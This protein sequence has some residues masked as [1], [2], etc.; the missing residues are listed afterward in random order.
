MPCQR[1]TVARMLGESRRCQRCL[2]NCLLVKCVHPSSQLHD[3]SAWQA[4]ELLRV[5]PAPCV[6][7]ARLPYPAE[8][9]AAEG[10]SAS[11]MFTQVPLAD[12]AA[13]GSLICYVAPLLHCVRIDHSRTFLQVLPAAPSC[14]LPCGFL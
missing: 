12:P 4:A 1:S 9:E 8:S 3:A 6:P 7:S 14:S 10:G 2:P 5:M 13:A 11:H